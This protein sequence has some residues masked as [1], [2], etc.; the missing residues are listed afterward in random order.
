MAE[1]KERNQGCRGL[2]RIKKKY[3]VW[4]YSNEDRGDA[5]FVWITVREEGTQCGVGDWEER[6]AEQRVCGGEECVDDGK[7]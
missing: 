2:Q 7:L 4:V 1:E 5:W 6:S 3:I